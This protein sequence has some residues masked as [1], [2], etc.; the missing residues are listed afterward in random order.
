MRKEGDGKGIVIAS[1]ER[2]SNSLR[3]A[4]GIA[5]VARI[6][7]PVAPSSIRPSGSMTTIAVVRCGSTLLKQGHPRFK[8][9]DLLSLYILVH[10]LSLQSARPRTF[11]S[12]R[13]FGLGSLEWSNYEVV[14]LGQDVGWKKV[15]LQFNLL[16]TLKTIERACQ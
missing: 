5:R 11:T 10:A 13:S 14:K 15:N 7:R 1:L 6:T 12:T 4:S 9:S 8:G 3:I 2:K 16:S